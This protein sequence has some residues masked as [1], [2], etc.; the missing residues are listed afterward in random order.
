MKHFVTRRVLVTLVL[1][2]AFFGTFTAGTVTGYLARP[3]LAAEEP[4]EFAVFW[5][6]WDIV[7]NHFVDRDKLDFTRMTYGAIQGMLDSL[8]D[9]GHTAFFSPEVAQAENNALEGSFEGIGA[10]VD[11]QGDQVKI[12]APIR[13]SPAEEAGVLAGDVILAVDGEEVTGLP[14]WEVISKVRGPAGSKV[15]LTILHP[16]ATDS[17]DIAIVRARIDVE[18]VSWARV[19]GTDVAYVQITQFASDTGDEL[20]RALTEI[21]AEKAAGHPISGILLDLR[22]NPGGLLNQAMRVGSQFLPAGEIILNERNAQ[23]KVSNYKSL[24]DGLGRE[25]PMVVLINEG[26]ASASEILAG[27]LQDHGRAKLVGMTTVGTGTVLVPFT[28]SDGSMIRLGVTNWLTPNMR[29]IKN[30]GIEPDVKVEQEASVEKIDAVL[31]QQTSSQKTLPKADEQFNTALK[32]L[33]TAVAE[34]SE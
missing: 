31:L 11:A 25:L 14:Q 20:K 23:G 10:Y 32:L 6:A 12:I 29:L 33:Q 7:N 5:E 27:A 18:S 34:Q 4:K 17:V 26:S 13:G 22:N 19:P 8:G 9:Q 24:G 1:A 15:T 16:N 21:N 30:Q 28:L 3:V 2:V